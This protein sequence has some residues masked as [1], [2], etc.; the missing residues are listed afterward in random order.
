MTKWLTE[1]ISALPM[2]EGTFFIKNSATGDEALMTEEE[3]ISYLN[4]HAKSSQHIPIGDGVHAILSALGF[5][6]CLPCAKRRAALN[7][8]IR[9]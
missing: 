4:E 6:S 9:K 3:V 7:R 1:S 5:K 2:G 8:L